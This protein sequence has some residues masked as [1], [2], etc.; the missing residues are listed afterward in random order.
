MA[1]TRLEFFPGSAEL[2][3]SAFP[4]YLKVNGRPVLAFDASAD[5][6]CYYT[7][8][9]PQGLTGTI[10]LV[11]YYFM[12]SATSGNIHFEAAFEAIT[13]VADG[14]DLDAQTSFATVNA[15]SDA[16]PGTAGYLDAVTITMTNDDGIA[17]G[18]IG[19]LVRLKI[20]RDV[21]GAG[22]ASGDCYVTGIELRDNA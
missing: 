16:V 9:A 21:G 13:P 7:F 4:Q 6:T 14:L 5:E 8:I 15:G 10:Q 11:V 12:A 22:N 3:A 18:D 2:P 20:N 1:N 19:D 17:A